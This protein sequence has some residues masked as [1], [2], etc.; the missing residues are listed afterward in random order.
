MK[1][2]IYYTILFTFVFPVN[3]GTNFTS[4][5]YDQYITGDDGILRM[6]VNIMGHVKQPGSYLVQDNIN[7]ISC[8]SAAGGY[9]PGANLKKIVIFRDEKIFKK[10]NFYNYLNENVPDTR[11]IL[12]PGDTIYI[13]E[14]I[15]SRIFYS[16]NLPSMI[17]SLLNVLIALN[18]S[19]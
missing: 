19:K 15:S 9:K 1:H 17:L 8:L 16:S 10:L 14:K 2:L 4:N 11:I 12:L 6:N 13:D 5:V 7:L 3:I 18:N